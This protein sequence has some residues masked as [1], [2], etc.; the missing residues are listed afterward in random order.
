MMGTISR[1]Q[2]PRLPS[3][4]PKT[5]LPPV[6]HIASSNLAQHGPKWTKQNLSVHW[7][8]VRVI[9]SVSRRHVSSMPT[10]YT[11]Q[12]RTSLAS[13]I[14]V[15][16]GLCNSPGINSIFL[17]LFFMLT[18]KYNLGCQCHYQ[19]PRCNVT[20]SANQSLSFPPF[21]LHPLVSVPT[22]A[23]RLISNSQTTR[24][25]SLTSP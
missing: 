23:C 15:G 20:E 3:T 24:P 14:L 19:C 17:T 5:R 10:R 6:S 25:L 7:T 21:P 8:R 16:P 11:C 1:E 9:T 2:S 13:A 4:N 22:T 18:V 12:T